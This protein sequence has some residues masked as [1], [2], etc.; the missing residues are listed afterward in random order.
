MRRPVPNP[1]S[2]MA[3]QP[4][5][6]LRGLNPL[7][8]PGFSGWAG[9]CRGLS[10]LPSPPEPSGASVP[11][12]AGAGGGVEAA[13]QR[14][15]PSSQGA[16]PVLGMVWMLWKQEV[17]C[18]ELIDVGLSR[19]AEGGARAACV[20]SGISSPKKP[21]ISP[22]LTQNSRKCSQQMTAPKLPSLKPSKAV[23]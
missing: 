13:R 18:W 4:G 21:F 23:P 17:G 3:M 8:T 12:G 15:C 1:A 19:D 6:A 22:V 9:G 2:P 14:P 5:A 11:P 20:P 10:P 16:A 7:P